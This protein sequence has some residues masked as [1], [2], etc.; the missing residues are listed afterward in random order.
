MRKVTKQEILSVA[1]L[2]ALSKLF[3]Q[4]R[5][6]IVSAIN[7]RTDDTIWWEVTVN[8]VNR[9][10]LPPLEWNTKRKTQ[11]FSLELRNFTDFQQFLLRCLHLKQALIFPFSL[12]F[13][14]WELP[15]K[16]LISVLLF[17]LLL[18]LFGVGTFCSNLI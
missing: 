11:I 18:L 6:E 15:R 4:L 1:A 17:L 16:V 8:F 14:P 13:W 5:R 7:Q 3:Y 2:F 9:L 12:V 10:N